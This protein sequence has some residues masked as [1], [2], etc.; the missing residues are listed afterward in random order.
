MP[1]MIPAVS[2]SA[3][4]FTNG[5]IYTTGRKQGATD[6]FRRNYFYDVDAQPTF[7][8]TWVILG[9]GH[10]DYLDF[11]QNMVFNLSQT[12]GYEDPPMMSNNCNLAGGC[13]ANANV[14]LQSSYSTMECSICENTAYAGNIDFDT[15]AVT[16]SV[17]YLKD[18]Q[19]MWSLL[20]PGILPAPSDGMLA[21]ANELQAKLAGKIK[22][23]GGEI[24]SC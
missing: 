24:P 18:Y 1:E 22:S 6:T 4:G 21:G 3:P 17:S 16:G 5:M 14:K 15:E 12:N 9:D 19:E 13:K 7:S 10:E 2:A 23:F 20:C 8:H 11:H